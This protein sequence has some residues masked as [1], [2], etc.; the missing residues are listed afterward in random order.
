MEASLILF[1][2]LTLTLDFSKATTEL[3]IPQKKDH[4]YDYYN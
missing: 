1:V 2:N 3:L 4:S